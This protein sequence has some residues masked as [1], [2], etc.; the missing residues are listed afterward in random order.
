MG[1]QKIKIQIK[2]QEIVA[3]LFSKSYTERLQFFFEMKYYV[4]VNG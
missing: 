4:A 3:I 2:I 1:I